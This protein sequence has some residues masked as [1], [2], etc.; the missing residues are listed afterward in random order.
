MIA[1]RDPGIAAIWQ[2]VEHGGKRY[3]QIKANRAPSGSSTVSWYLAVPPPSYRDNGSNWIAVT[4]DL[5][6]AMPVQVEVYKA[7]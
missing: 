7:P 4:P 3:L 6:L 5:D 2:F 1:H